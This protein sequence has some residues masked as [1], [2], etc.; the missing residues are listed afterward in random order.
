VTRPIIRLLFIPREPYPT[1]RVRINVLF[2]QELL[3]RGHA[4]DLVMQAA[5]ERVPSGRHEWFGRT[6]WVGT[7]DSRD[8]FVHRIH[9]HWRGLLH[10]LRS[11]RLMR[12]S[13]YDGVLLSD[14]F[15]LAC[16]ALPI[17]H[18][19]KMKFIFWLTFP[20]P[21]IELQ[22]A[23][24]RTSR[25]PRVA[26]IRGLVSGWALYKW[27]LPH[28][29]YVFVQSERMKRNICAHGI[30]AEKMSPI[31]TGFDLGSISTVRRETESGRRLSVALAYLGTLAAERH[32]EVLVDML[33]LLRNAGTEARLL[34]VGGADR[35]RDRLMLERRTEGLGISEHVEI[36]G[37]LP[38]HQ[39]LERVARADIC[40][41]PIF[42]S[43]IFDVGSPTK[44]MEYLALGIPVV[45]NDH[46]EQQQIL[47]AS[48]AGVC[49][50]WGARHF[51]R[52]VRWLMERS[53]QERSAM[54]ARGR[55][56]AEANRTY[57]RIADD[58]EHTCLT[59][60]ALTNDQ[61]KG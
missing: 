22:G 40:L 15:L 7:T 10:D 54:G 48:R 6:A 9:K 21:E 49:V 4:I 20:Y 18:Y 59:V 38:H 13:Q 57:A 24:D 46:P 32:L 25:Y 28:S 26:K 2:G 5:D 1:D 30:D 39:A 60:L 44:L 35:P 33:A 17:A 11:L 61:R 43:P 19:R 31:V 29:D 12:P 27:I 52:A 45:A 34:L 3:S 50:P 37:F 23:R 56:W 36:T 42:R 53:A 55:A 58:V 14:K 16:I 51:A 8:G 47:H 41:S